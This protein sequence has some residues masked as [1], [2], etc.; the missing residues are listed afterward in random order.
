MAPSSSAFLSGKA[1]AAVA[2]AIPRVPAS[3]RQSKHGAVLRV[4]SAEPVTDREPDGDKGGED[5]ARTITDQG[6]H[7]RP[8]VGD[9]RHQ[10]PEEQ[11]RP[12]TADWCGDPPGQRR[13]RIS[14]EQPRSERCEHADHDGADDGRDRDMEVPP[15]GPAEELDRERYEDDGK[16]G[17]GHEEPDG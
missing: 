17:G 10:R 4:W 14:D 3:R 9:E 1:A 5:G 11:N 15:E 6:Q 7:R 13:R 8:V 16:Q 2:N 12:D